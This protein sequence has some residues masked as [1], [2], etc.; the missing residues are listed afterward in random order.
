MNTKRQHCLETHKKNCLKTRNPEL[1]KEWDYERN[2]KIS[3]ENVTAGSKIKVWWVCKNNHVWR[4]TVNNRTRGTKCPYCSGKKAY[5]ENCLKTKY[6]ELCME[7]DYDKNILSPEDVTVGSCKEVWWV[8][9]NNH[10]WQEQI[11]RRSVCN[12]KCPYCSGK[13]ACEENCL[14]TKNPELCKEWDYNKNTLSPENVTAGSGKKVWWICKNNHNWQEQIYNRSIC[15]YKCPYCSGK[16]ACEENCLK[17]KNPE[18]CK[19][20]D[21]DKNILSPESVTASSNK[22]VWWKC[23]NNHEWYASI[24]SR[25]GGKGCPYCAGQKLCKENCLKTKNPELCEEW[26]YNKNKLL[27]E[28]VAANSKKKVWWVCENNHEWKANV[29]NRNYGS[30]CPFCS[31]NISKSCVIWLKSLNIN[32]TEHKIIVDNKKYYVDGFDKH[33][34]TIYEYLGSYWHGDPRKYNPLEINKKC[35]VS[36]RDLLE[37][38]IF[39]FNILYSEGYKIVY[40]W[41]YE[42]INKLYIPISLN[43]ILQKSL[44]IYENNMDKDILQQ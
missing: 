3:P 13:R 27:P 7:W 37:K 30:G 22:K 35:G 40:R 23:L 25:N 31:K 17:T 19:E 33:E 43:N 26:D 18:L 20:W 42:E 29:N 4:S 1:C 28:N 10:S 14:K 2:G 16:R 5:K 36:Y 24:A 34:K 6:P 39:R 12:F 15:N 44:F 32:K 9:K 11:Y 38:T 41:E 21:Y 8:C